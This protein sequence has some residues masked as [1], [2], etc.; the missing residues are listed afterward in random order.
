MKRKGNLYHLIYDL[1][2]LRL[3]DKKASRGKSFQKGVIDHRKNQEQNIS[4]LHFLLRNQEFKTSPYLNFQIKEDKIR[5]ISRLP[6]MPDRICQHAL[7]NI[8]EPILTASF[9]VDTY[10]AIKGKGL[11][12]ASFA[13]RDQLKKDS[14]LQYCLKLDIRK[15]Y[16]SVKNE[17]LKK[18]LRRK[19][20]CTNTLNLIDGIIDSA[21]GLPLGNYLSQPLAN[22]YLNGFD[23]YL[24]QDLKVE[25]YSRY[26]DDI[27][28]LADNKPYLHDL[29]IKIKEYLR[30]NLELEVK[31]NH[32]VFPVSRGIDFCGYVVYSTHVKLR[33]R[34]KKR[35]VKMMFKNRN[36]KS[37]ASYIGWMRHSNSKH[38]EKKYL[39][40]QS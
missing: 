19:L 35:F 5:D 24:K 34:I 32:Q 22:F 37:I 25:N 31:S 23:H 8:I 13:V 14:S 12:K 16:P 15:F 30:I 9:T 36:S 27:V 10:S 2:N 21:I 20:K 17:I 26:C 33:P 7:C 11:H 40:R 28:I 39:C 18:L 38:L 6:Y 3:A 1:D 4:K 29:L